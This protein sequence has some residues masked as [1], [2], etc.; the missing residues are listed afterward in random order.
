RLLSGRALQSELLYGPEEDVPSEVHDET[1]DAKALAEAAF[2]QFDSVRGFRQLLP[3][4]EV[5]RSKLNPV[6]LFCM[7]AEC[8][9]TGKPSVPYRKGRL[10]A[11]DYV[12]DA[13][14]FAGS[15]WNVWDPSLKGEGVIKHTKL[16]CWTLKPIII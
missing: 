9:A 2:S 4:Y 8:A 15:D 5:G 12:D 3:L 14:Q 10:A 7:M 16:Q 6:D 13:Y 11:A 1:F